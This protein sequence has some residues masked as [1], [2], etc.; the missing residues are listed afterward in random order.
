MRRYLLAVLAAGLL[1]TACGGQLPDDAAAVVGDEVI[2]I[3][4]LENLVRAQVADPTQPL[5]QPDPSQVATVAETQRQ[6]LSQLIQ[7]TIV[8]RAA[9]ELGIDVSEQQVDE[10]FAEFAAQFGGEEGLREEIR[11]QGR[12]V[13]DVRS[14]VAA[15]VRSEALS[16]HFQTATEV[17]EADIREAYEEGLETDYQVADVAHILVETEAEA[18]DILAALEDGADFAQLAEERSIDEFSA[19]QGGELGENPRGRFVQEFDDAVWS[20]EEGE[21]VGPIQTEFGFHIIHVRGFRTVGLAEVRDQ[22]REELQ[23]RQAQ[24]A[25]DAWYRQALREAEVRVDDRFG[26]WDPE[27]GEVVPAEPLPPGGGGS[28]QQLDVDQTP[29]PAESPTG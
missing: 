14:Q 7:D 19:V 11:R 13:E 6:V 25:F 21:I 29:A 12:T 5:A 8:A 3:S 27:V 16:E 15:I 2:S 4:T 23:G 17:S 22:I 26:R 1:A 18:E 10:R 20:A 9:T 24:E 28:P